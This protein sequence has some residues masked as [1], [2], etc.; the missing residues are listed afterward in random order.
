MSFALRALE[1]L[2]ALHSTRVNV[3]I[4][5]AGVLAIFVWALSYVLL[6]DQVVLQLQGSE[7]LNV[8]IE[9]NLSC[10][11]LLSVSNIYH[12]EYHFFNCQSCLAGYTCFH[13]LV[14]ARAF[15]FWFSFHHL[16]TQL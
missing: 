1:G 16:L 3:D 4:H 8:L 2:C 9:L 14:T 5:E 13:L 7:L 10:L 6:I 11:V 12:L 15:E